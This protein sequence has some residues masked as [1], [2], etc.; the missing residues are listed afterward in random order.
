M[1]YTSDT[2]PRGWAT[3]ADAA[4]GTTTAVMPAGDISLAPLRQ[5][6]F[7]AY[8]DSALTQLHTSQTAYFTF[9]SD[10]SQV[11]PAVPA[12]PGYTAWTWADYSLTGGDITVNGYAAAPAVYDH[13]LPSMTDPF[14]SDKV[15]HFEVKDGYSYGDSVW[16]ILLATEGYIDYTSDNPGYTHKWYYVPKVT[17]PAPQGRIGRMARAASEVPDHAVWITDSTTVPAGGIERFG[18]QST[19]D[20]YSVT[21]TDADG[22]VLGTGA[23]TVENGHNDMREFQNDVLMNYLT[24]LAGTV[25]EAPTGYRIALV[26]IQGASLTATAL[27]DIE[28]KV[29]YELISFETD[30]ETD[31]ETNPETEPE[32]QPETYPD[33]TPDTV[34]D[35][36]PDTTPDTQPET[37]PDTAPGTVVPGGETSPDTDALTMPGTGSETEPGDK[38]KGLAW[39]WILII[40]LLVIVIAACVI[41]LLLRRRGETVDDSTPPV[42]PV[43]EEPAPEPEPA[44]AAPLFVPLGEEIPEEEIPEEIEIVEEVTADTVDDLM[45]DIVAEHFLEN[46]AE[47]GGLGKLGIINVG[48][49]SANYNDGDTITLEDLQAKGLIE[50]NIGRLKVLAAGTLNKHLIVKA[51]AFSVQAIKMITLTGG[52]A[53]KLS[54]CDQ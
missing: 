27:R 7:N 28:V 35:T 19:V 41:I 33:T 50:D 14:G 24:T 23:Y 12:A 26:E 15:Y 51:D 21:F 36:V 40:I 20:E 52:H 45:T 46:T 54:G 18:V 43:T 3:T 42:P 13:P 17:A 31:P 53:V 34:P 29:T 10:K 25:A 44:P 37:Q 32:T 2:A 11:L 1:T 5:A 8:I 47:A 30:P 49:L 48:V 4:I 16:D 9:L 39:W 6:T 38:D 22:T